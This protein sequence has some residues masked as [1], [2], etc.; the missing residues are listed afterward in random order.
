M[1][2][3]KR[4]LT[5]PLPKKQKHLWLHTEVW[6][7]ILQHTKNITAGYELTAIVANLSWRNLFDLRA[8]LVEVMKFWNKARPSGNRL[9]FPVHFKVFTLTFPAVLFYYRPHYNSDVM[10]Q[11]SGVLELHG[12]Q[13]RGSDVW[14]SILV[15]LK[16][17][18]ARLDYQVV[19]WPGSREV[20]GPKKAPG[21][22][23]VS[24]FVLI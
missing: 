10:T 2:A 23:C 1:T 6:C 5:E 20:Q 9:N 15:Q 12:S 19:N 14:S 18:W 11:I 3:D 22:L 21:L 17:L 4:T 8:C 16:N 13:C 7:N 24:W